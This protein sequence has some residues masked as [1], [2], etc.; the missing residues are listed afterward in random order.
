MPAVTLFVTPNSPMRR[1]LKSF[2]ADG[3][4]PQAIRHTEFP[5]EEGTEIEHRLDRAVR[6]GM[7]TPNSPMR[8]GLK[9]SVAARRRQSPSQVTPN[10]PMRRG[11]K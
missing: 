11:L 5:D 4:R 1:G 6:I 8:R 2:V 7:V 9:L 10:S 3:F